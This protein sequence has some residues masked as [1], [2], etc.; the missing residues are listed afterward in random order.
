MVG[1]WDL[2]PV[3]L[4]TAAPSFLRCWYKQWGPSQQPRHPIPERLHPSPFHSDRHLVS[5]AVCIALKVGLYSFP[6]L[7]VVPGD[8][9]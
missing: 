3:H 1:A 9:R 7:Y 6:G 2:G 4:R 5:N 8:G